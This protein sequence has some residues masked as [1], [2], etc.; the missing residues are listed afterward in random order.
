MWMIIEF[1]ECSGPLQK[2]MIYQVKK[3]GLLKKTSIA[4][5]DRNTCYSSSR[6]PMQSSDLPACNCQVVE[7]IRWIFVP[8]SF[9]PSRRILGGNPSPI[10]C[11][12]HCPQWQSLINIGDCSF[13]FSSEL[14]L[15]FGRKR[16]RRDGERKKGRKRERKRKKGERKRGGGG[17]EEGKI[18]LF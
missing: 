8:I 11:K 12:P 1:Q 5:N 4:Q 10:R 2:Q 9:S 14:L 6:D 3:I 15:L 17:R 13:P 7:E 16:E 18:C